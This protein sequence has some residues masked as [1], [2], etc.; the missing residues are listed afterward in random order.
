MTTSKLALFA[1]IAASSTS[2]LTISST[3][4]PFYVYKGGRAKYRK[5]TKNDL[6][7][8]NRLTKRRKRN[9]VAAKSRRINRK[10]K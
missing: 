3:T 7:F 9:K 4:D 5:P 8:F 2:A 1:A 10:N 6:Y